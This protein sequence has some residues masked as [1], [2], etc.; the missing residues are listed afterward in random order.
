MY[1]GT[2][3]LMGNAAQP[4]SEEI[5]AFL[6]AA[7]HNGCVKAAEIK[8]SKLKNKLSQCTPNVDVSKS[9]VLTE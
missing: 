1:K 8:F 4:T 7:V 9:N 3:I 5:K 6:K 2:I